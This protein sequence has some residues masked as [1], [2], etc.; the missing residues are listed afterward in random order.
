VNLVR[1]SRAS[2]LPA[3]KAAPAAETATRP[4]GVASHDNHFNFLRL[5][6]ASLVLLAHAPE[7]VDGDRRREPLTRLFGTLSCGDL[8]VAGFFVL[9][10]FLIIQSWQRRHALASFLGSRI[11][12]IYP[13]FAAASVISVAVIGAAGAADASRYLAQVDWHGLSRSVLLLRSPA[14]PPTF[15]GQPY[16]VI[17]GNLWTISYEFA[18]YLCA[19]ILGA[20]GVVRR[21]NLFLA[22]TLLVAAGWLLPLPPVVHALGLFAV[23]YH[24]GVASLHMWF[25]LLLLSQENALFLYLLLLFCA[26]GCFALFRDRIRFSASWALAAT[27]ALVP[28]MYL[29]F[30][31]R[32]GLATLGAY[33]FFTL[34]FARLPLL[35]PFKGPLDISYGIYL[36]GWP[37]EKLIVWQWPA[38]SPWALFGLSLPASAAAGWLSWRLLEGPCLRLKRGRATRPFAPRADA[39]HRAAAIAFATPPASG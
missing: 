6:L 17:N 22:F 25:L 30:T 7:L 38:W 33:A 16:P 37:I 12:R 9:S 32:L 3:R 1:I 36:Y 27:V 19:A 23:H 35:A 39:S 18:C 21:R 31:A 10:G 13:G 20:C 28:C 11:L 34:A 4:I 14:A 2:S 26:G 8:A 29:G 24:F 5:L 15:V